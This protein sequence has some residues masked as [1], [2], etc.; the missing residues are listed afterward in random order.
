[1][2]LRFALLLSAACM[3]PLPF[4]HSIKRMTR[5]KIGE[6]FWLTGGRW[7][8]IA[9]GHGERTWREKEEDNG[10]GWVLDQCLFGDKNKSVWV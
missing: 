3:G 1:M 9:R 4:P 7:R 10:K 5:A 6:R 2:H 8:E